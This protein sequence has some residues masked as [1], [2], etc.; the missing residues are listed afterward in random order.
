MISIRPSQ[1]KVHAAKASKRASVPMTILLYISMLN[2]D[3]KILPRGVIQ[4]NRIM[5]APL[6]CN[7]MSASPRLLFK[8]RRQTLYVR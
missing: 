2:A 6:L 3:L 7:G 5:M 1:R 4:V 8:Q